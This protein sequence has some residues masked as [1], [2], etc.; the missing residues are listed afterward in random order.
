MAGKVMP[1]KTRRPRK[2]LDM[3]VRQIEG[4]RRG[5]IKVCGSYRREKETVG[6]LD[7]LTGPDLDFGE[8][9][10]WFTNVFGYEEIRGG[11]LKSEGITEYKGGP[12][13]LN[14]WRV[15]TVSAWGAMTLFTT[16]PYD[17]NIMMR[18]RAQIREWKLSQYGLFDGETQLDT[19]ESEEDIFDRLELQ[20]ITPVQRED[21]RTYLLPKDK[22]Q[23]DF[24]RIVNVHSSRPNHPPHQVRLE[25][26]E[27]EF[28]EAVECECE[29][30]TYRKTKCRH[31]KEAEVT[32]NG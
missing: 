17:L 23:A 26:R 31:M 22:V 14:L 2:D 20:Y 25:K 4:L 28:W 6:D 12:L 29:H 1:S 11:S 10:E 18:A 15:P 8:M 32:A 5:E 16:G 3:A 9:V 24:G 30:F 13:I 27:N 19:G 21:W 7:I